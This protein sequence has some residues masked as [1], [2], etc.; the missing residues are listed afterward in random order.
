MIRFSFVLLMLLVL[1]CPA[2]GTDAE[3][4]GNPDQ[5]DG[6]NVDSACAEEGLSDC[7]GQ[8]ADL[9]TDDAHCGSC[10][11]ACPTDTRCVLGSCTCP[12]G[13]ALCEAQCVDLRRDSNHCGVCGNPCLGATVC[14]DS[15]CLC[16][17][18]GT[19][20][21][22]ECVDTDTDRSNCGDCGLVCEPGTSCIKGHCR[23]PSGGVAC[24]GECVDIERDRRHCGGCFN[25]CAGEK[26]CEGGDCVCENGG[27]LCDGVC[28]DTVTDERHCGGCF[29]ECLGAST[30]IGSICSCGPDLRYCDGECVS[31]DSDPQNCGRCDFVCPD[32]NQCYR[33]HC[34][35]ATDERCD[36][37]D[38]DLDGRTDEA[39]SDQPL[40]R[41]CDN[42][43]GAGN[44]T[45]NRGEWVNCTA[46]HAVDEI[47][48]GEDN[49]CDG[50]TDEDV[51]TVYYEDYDRDGFGDPDMTWA[52]MACEKPDYPSENGGVYVDNN[53]DCDDVDRDTH[54][55]AGEACDG[56]DN[57]C[58]GNTDEACVCQPVGG[59]RP[60]GT[61]EGICHMGQQNCTQSG[62]SACSGANYVPPALSESCN[63]Q[64]DDCDGQTDEDLADDAYE[65][66]DT[67]AGAALLPTVAEF[68]PAL[69]VSHLSLYH[70]QSTTADRDWYAFTAAEGN[71][72]GACLVH[73]L[74][75]QCGFMLEV[76]LT[77]PN[78]TYKNDYQVCLYAGN[79]SQLGTAFCTD[80]GDWIASDHA[81]VLWLTWDGACGVDDSWD[82][83]AQVRHPGSGA[84]ICA[85]Y[86][87]EVDM[88]W[89]GEIADSCD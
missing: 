67:C 87:L 62:W 47:C 49:D 26:V 5:T 80:A 1:L 81:Y 13:R 57:D 12:D 18:G 52:V 73:W 85:S 51:T 15:E 74:T 75:P 44:E 33:G 29:N 9:K 82:F 60:C 48:D 84:D 14:V 36:G 40:E 72:L 42:L 71:H 34:L 10:E 25:E 6:D 4:S 79:C 35:S 32:D 24:D 3:Q 54:P 16:M 8:C 83:L 31:T 23:C 39:D 22:G 86:G 63:R 19:S 7:E 17:N 76:R 88:W 46:P 89:D 66:N 55:G 59:T 61:D 70:G 43:C 20:C 56:E 78:D 28:V 77:V 69:G 53:A 68:D 45:C 38:N 2:C 65:P 41:P 37:V 21:K 50:L 30:C 11:I 64:D 27:M 58:D